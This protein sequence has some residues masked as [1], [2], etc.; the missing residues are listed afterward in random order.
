MEASLSSKGRE[1]RQKRRR[2]FKD[3]HNRKQRTMA[4]LQKDLEKTICLVDAA[5]D[6]NN[7]TPTLSKVI[8]PSMYVC[9]CI[10]VFSVCSICI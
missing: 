1:Q 10:D 2:A 6:L 3:S 5:K 8:W 7:N 9:V 4:K